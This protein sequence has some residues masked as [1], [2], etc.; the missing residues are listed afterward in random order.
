MRVLAA[1]VLAL[2]LAAFSKKA[3]APLN[4]PTFIAEGNPPLLSDWGMVQASQQRLV[5]SEGVTP[6]DLNTPLFT[7]YAQ[8]LRT[9]WMPAGQSAE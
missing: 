4:A 3:A 8:K 2:L 5:L 6:Y 1:L 9:I 7:D